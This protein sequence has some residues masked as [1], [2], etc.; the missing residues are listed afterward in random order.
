MRRRAKI[1]REAAAK[2]GMSKER[3]TVVCVAAGQPGPYADT[4]Y[5]YRVLFE[6]QGIPGY[7]NPDAPFVPRDG[8]DEERVRRHC[9]AICG[10]Y[11]HGDPQANWS[12]PFL[13]YLKKI[14]PGEWEFSV[15]EAFTD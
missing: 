6:W 3:I 7:R 2:T 5:T 8:L 9:R 13:D 4:V 10:W 12:S 11:E 15:R 1:L 14:G